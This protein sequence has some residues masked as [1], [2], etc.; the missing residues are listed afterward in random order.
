MQFVIVGNRLRPTEPQ[1]SSKNIIALN[2]LQII[3]LELF[4][5]KIRSLFPAE[6]GVRLRKDIHQGRGVKGKR[7][8]TDKGEEGKKKPKILQMSFMNVQFQ[9]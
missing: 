6:G 8:N 4:H 9:N 3:A 1:E 7:K 2:R 5:L